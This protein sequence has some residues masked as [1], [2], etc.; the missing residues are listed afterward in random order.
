MIMVC[1]W[2]G[3]YHEHEPLLEDLEDEKLSKEEQTMAW[4]S[5]QHEESVPRS[6]ASST[7]SVTSM[8]FQPT[9]VA[10]T[11]SFSSVQSNPLS[12]PH[13]VAQN[14]VPAHV[15]SVPCT[16]KTHA[17][18]LRDEKISLGNS[19]VCKNCHEKIDWESI[20]RS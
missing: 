19:T 10:S 4:E 14:Y 8:P 12:Q 3:R 16:N 2:I 11:Y 1:R 5:F 7:P 15:G 17:I 18:Q 20:Q 13:L 6:L 9:N